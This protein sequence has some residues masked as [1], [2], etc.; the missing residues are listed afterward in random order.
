MTL[1]WTERDLDIVET[2][3]RRVRLLTVEQVARIWW[4][5]ASRLR[6]VH[7]RLR[8]L[9]SGALLHR[10]IVNVHPLLQL[11]RPL[12]AWNDNNAEPNF[13]R[14]STHARARWTRPAHPAEVYSAT[15]V[16]ANLFG[17]TATQLPQ[18]NHRDHDLLLGEVYVLYR[19][20]RPA[21][22]RKWIGED[23]LGKA[24]YGIKDPDAFLI[25]DTGAKFRVIESAGRYSPKQIESFHHHC[26]ENELPYELW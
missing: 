21:E 3:T 6:I 12:L 7:R 1:E 20:E 16:A 2:L 8:R 14:A 11:K 18:L 22:A 5:S 4:P 17:S 9:T 26:V 10:T 13:E 24:G 23:A 25:D 15:P 19:T